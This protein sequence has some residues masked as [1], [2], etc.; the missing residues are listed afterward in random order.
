MK[1]RLSEQKRKTVKGLLNNE[2]T[3][4]WFTYL[5]TSAFEN[6]VEFQ[7]GGTGSRG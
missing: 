4:D 3:D 6:K 2:V 1:N 7:P 5:S